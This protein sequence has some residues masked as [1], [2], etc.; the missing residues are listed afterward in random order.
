MLG[1]QQ[2]ASV[3]QIQRGSPAGLLLPVPAD[4][5]PGLL[6]PGTMQVLCLV[7]MLTSRCVQRLSRGM[8]W[9]SC[10]AHTRDV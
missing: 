9:S 1:G 6:R 2:R 10:T 3:S 8:A 7:G 4:D 5:M